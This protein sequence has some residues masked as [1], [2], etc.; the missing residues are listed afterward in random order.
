MHAYH[1]DHYQELGLARDADAEAIRAAYRTLAKQLHPDLSDPAGAE[2]K[3]PF[4]RLQEAYDVLRDPLRRAQYD[5]ELARQAEMVAAARAA[6]RTSLV[7]VAAMAPPKPPPPGPGFRLFVAALSLVAVVTS[8][9]GVWHF[10]LRPRPVPVLTVTAEQDDARNRSRRPSPSGADG[11]GTPA[12]PSILKRAVDRVVQAQVERVEAARKHME[13]T[14]AQ[15]SALD[16]SKGARPGVEAARAVPTMLVSRVECI[17]FGTK[18]VLSRDNDGTKVSFD[19][20]PAVQ[21]RVSDLGAG[22]VLVSRIEPTNK[23]ALGF[24]KGE[25]NDTKMLI[26]DSAG[27]VQATFNVEC[28]A[29]AF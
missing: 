15:L 2:S 27:K 10:F 7:P 6:V 23:Y 1:P 19:A 5:G 4:L 21:P 18:I 17:G 28:T 22:A 25:R 29:A 11:P 3:V 12:N 20:K 14:E 26:F 9:I 13:A 8:C 24:T 16:N